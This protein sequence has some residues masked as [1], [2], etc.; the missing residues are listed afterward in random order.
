[1][2]V[3]DKVRGMV[4][5][6]VLTFSQFHYEADK[7]GSNLQ[8][9][10]SRYYPH[11]ALIKIENP[12]INGKIIDDSY[13]KNQVLVRIP[14]EKDEG[15]KSFIDVVVNKLDAEKI[16][17]KEFEATKKRNCNFAVGS[18]V[19]PI[20]LDLEMVVV[21]VKEDHVL[22]HYQNKNDDLIVK[23]LPFYHFESDLES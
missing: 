23:E 16:I 22:V 1:M 3:G 20:G 10:H 21:G 17:I 18:K 19:K 15:P 4:S 11:L 13:N 7:C 9:R 12:V 14:Y 2:R 6:I 8:I 5:E